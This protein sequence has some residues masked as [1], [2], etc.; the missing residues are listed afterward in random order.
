[1]NTIDIYDGFV[2]NL[3]WETKN[4]ARLDNLYDRERA[5][6]CSNT[7]YQ[8]SSELYNRLANLEDRLADLED[9]IDD[10]VIK[11]NDSN[12]LFVF[13]PDQNIRTKFAFSLS[14]EQFNELISKMNK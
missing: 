4:A 7:S 1:M 8:V 14:D 5:K 9:R 13:A 10:L 3:D 6:Y 12:G 2:E 11:F